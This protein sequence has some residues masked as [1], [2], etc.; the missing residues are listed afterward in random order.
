MV[1]LEQLENFMRL[2]HAVQNVERVARIPNETKLRN[3]AEHTFELAMVCWYLNSANNLELDPEKVLKYALAHD[4]VEAYAGDSYIFDEASR[5]DKVE[6]EEKATEQLRDDFTEFPELIEIIAKYEK[7]EDRESRFV[8][9]ADKLIDPLNISMETKN[10]FWKEKA[11]SY[12]QVRNYKEN[13]ITV[14][15]DVEAYWHTLC[16]KLETNKDFFF[17]E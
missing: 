3:T 4:L 6:R 12:K 2:L 9:A 7:R 16:Q 5:S 15:K 8:Y 17:D 10:S 1:P 11:V 13:K 14:S